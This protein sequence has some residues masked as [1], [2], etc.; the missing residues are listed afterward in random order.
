[1]KRL[2]AALALRDN[3]R[4]RE[5]LRISARVPDEVG[6]KKSSN[7]S[8]NHYLAPALNLVE[9]NYRTKIKS[10]ELAELCGMS[11]FQFGR[12][13][14]ETFG[15]SFRGY[16]VRYRLMQ[17]ARLLENPGASVTEV[18][19]AV[20][21]NDSSYFT[22]TFKRYF[23]VLPSEAVGG[24]FARNHDLLESSGIPEGSCG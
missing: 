24:D 6:T 9:K 11:P 2:F 23:G 15:V 14:Q 5:L 17:S 18:A 13:F 8:R 19:Y 4:N 1:M 3:Q 22:R 7:I 20:G 12:A 21:F 10:S 16:V